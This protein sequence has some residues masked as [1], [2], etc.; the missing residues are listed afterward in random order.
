M[1]YE[2]ACRKLDVEDRIERAAFPVY[3]MYPTTA[4]P[5]EVRLGPFELSVAMQAPPADGCFPLV[6]ISHG[7]SSSPL[8]F[9]GLAAELAA[10]GYFV[11]LPQ[12]AYDNTLDNSRQYTDANLRD[13]PRHL[14]LA[15]DAALADP[16]LRASLDPKQV[17]VIGHSVGG[18][19]ALAAAGGRPHT[20][21][22]IA[23]CNRPENE[24]F[25]AWTAIIRRNGLSEGPVRVSSDP[26][27][28]ALVLLAPDLSTFMHDDALSQIGVPVMLRVAEKDLWAEE[29]IAILRKGLTHPAAT[30]DW[31][32]IPNAGHYAF[33]SPF[34]EA[35][36]GRVGEAAT[37]PEG[38]D[39][40]AFQSALAAEIAEFLLR[41]RRAANAG[42]EGHASDR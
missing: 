5:N 42:C 31:A 12:H 1:R 39:R 23:F 15:I 4:E 28:G 41:R 21:E 38:F 40:S 13:R 26:R 19:G 17:S 6:V 16:R 27:I 34:P 20:A 33:I 24:H 37:D 18:Y 32:L 8:V 2:V 29:A 22:L 10:R 35:L 7:S 9:R 14:G 11:C 25:P 3:V 36:K 30:L